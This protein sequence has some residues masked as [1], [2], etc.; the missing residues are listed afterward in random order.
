MKGDVI[1]VE[2]PL[3]EKERDILRK[4]YPIGPLI[5]LV[6]S[7]RHY[8]IDIG[9]GS[10]I[11]FTGKDLILTNSDANVQHTSIEQFSEGRE[12]KIDI[13][14]KPKYDRETI[15]IRSLK[16]VGSNFGGYDLLRNNC[17]HFAYWCVT[18]KRTSRQVFFLN[19][20]QNIIEKAVENIFESIL[21]MENTMTEYYFHFLKSIKHH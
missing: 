10:I 16:K 15:S 7:Y 21:K 8:G 14:V 1:Y 2:L 3:T 18:G 12:S 19:D 13:I 11:H 17:E 20:D 4:K 9:D 5:N 6:S